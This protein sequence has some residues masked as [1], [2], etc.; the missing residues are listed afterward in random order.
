M[1]GEEFDLWE[2]GA[3]RAESK[4]LL[5]HSRGHFIKSAE[6]VTEDKIALLLQF[7]GKDLIRRGV[8]LATPKRPIQQ[9][10][11][12]V[13]D[14]VSRS[15]RP[16][17]LLRDF[18]KGALRHPD[19]KDILPEWGHTTYPT[20]GGCGLEGG[21]GAHPRALYARFYPS[22]RRYDN[23]AGL[24]ARM[25][26]HADGPRDGPRGNLDIR[27]LQ[28]DP[29]RTPISP[30]PDEAQSGDPTTVEIMVPATKARALRT[31]ASSSTRSGG[32]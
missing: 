7:R 12:G 17:V 22:A 8:V 3:E 6:D 11:E 13:W 9:V 21:R 1:E 27:H 29:Q 32:C 23:A 26:M 31:G 18:N 25:R 28:G 15:P 30:G 24:G 5:V 20:K 10:L 14:L 4:A 2:L 16:L 19:Y